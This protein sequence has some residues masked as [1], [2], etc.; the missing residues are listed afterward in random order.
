MLLR[1][2]ALFSGGF[3]LDAAEAV[4]AFDGLDRYDVLELLSG[5][6]TARSSCSTTPV[7]IPVPTARDDQAVR[8][9]PSRRG[10]RGRPGARPAPRP[11]RPAG[12][13]LAPDL[14]TGAQASSRAVL[15]RE[16][17]N[18][19][20]ALAHA[21]HSDDPAVLADLAFDLVF[22][23]FQTARFADGDQWLAS[24]RGPPDRPRVPSSADG[25]CGAGATSTTTSATF[26]QVGR[27]GPGRDGGRGRGR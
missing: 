6:S 15:E 26:R 22:Y 13:R 3:T 25:S 24:R 18:L 8:P 12:R 9:C 16:N 20:V 1:R 23:W 4:A 17:E 14:E 11:L 5:S 21:A 10:R 27:A 2:L 7:R 19:H